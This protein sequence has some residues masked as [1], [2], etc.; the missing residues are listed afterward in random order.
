M[1]SA[2]IRGDVHVR[3]MQSMGMLLLSLLPHLFMLHACSRSPW[4]R[5]QPRSWWTLECT[6]AD[7]QLT[8][9]ICGSE[10]AAVAPRLDNGADSRC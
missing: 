3:C 9:I 4:F 7:A 2:A 8:A 1:R 6:Q 5:G 10:C